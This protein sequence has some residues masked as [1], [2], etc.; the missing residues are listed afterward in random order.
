MGRPSPVQ[1]HGQAWFFNAQPHPR[2]GESITIAVPKGAEPYCA[3]TKIGTISAEM[4]RLGRIVGTPG[5]DTNWRWF[6]R[7]H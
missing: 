5:G 2:T 6:W 7:G 1:V 4:Y 3:D